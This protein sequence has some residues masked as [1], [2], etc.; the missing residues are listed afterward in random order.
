MRF[1]ALETKYFSLKNVI[2]VIYYILNIQARDS[3]ILHLGIVDKEELTEP[4]QNCFLSVT[5]GKYTLSL[6]KCI[7]VYNVL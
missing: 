4:E 3:K 1:I 5:E 7:F 2:G 6:S